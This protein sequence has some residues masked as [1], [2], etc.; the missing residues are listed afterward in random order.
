MSNSFIFNGEIVWRPTPEYVDRSHLKRFMA[1]HGIASFAELQQRSTSDIGWFTE[2][3]LKYLDIQFSHPYSQII[4]LAG[5]IQKPT[6]C[7]GGEL[8]IV[9]NCVDKWA[10]NPDTCDGT[11]IIWEGE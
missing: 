9:H 4:D 5:G 3:V 7:V 11:A 6:W 1:Q 2:A 8:N 10:A